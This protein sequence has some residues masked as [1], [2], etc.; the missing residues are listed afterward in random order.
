WLQTVDAIDAHQLVVL[1]TV[2]AIAMRMRCTTDLDLTG[3]SITRAQAQATN[4]V[5][6]NK[7]IA[8]HCAVAR[9]AQECDVVVYNFYN[10]ADCLQFIAL[11]NLHV[12][13]RVTTFVA[14]AA[15][16][17]TATTAAPTTVVIILVIVAAP[18][19]IT[20]IA[21]TV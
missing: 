16:T 2:A 12:V 13:V 10:A 3:Y 1:A 9:G 8:A 14:T 21:T 19:I 20:V 11:A 5:V 18:A 7:D 6:V 17:V 15:A 4:K